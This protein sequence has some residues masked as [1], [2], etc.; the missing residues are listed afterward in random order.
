[1]AKSTKYFENTIATPQFFILNLIC[2][3]NMMQYLL[4]IKY[5]FY[6]KIKLSIQL[7]LIPNQIETTIELKRMLG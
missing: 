2:K 3:H 4:Y 1:M 7:M 5:Y 6:F